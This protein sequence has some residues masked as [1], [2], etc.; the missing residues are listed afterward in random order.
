MRYLAI[1]SLE[2]LKLSMLFSM[3]FISLNIFV[4]LLFSPGYRFCR[5]F[6]A[7]C[8]Y[9]VVYLVPLC[10]LYMSEMLFGTFLV[11]A[12]DYE[13]YMM[14]QPVPVE[15]GSAF[16][17]SSA[18]SI[19]AAHMVERAVGK[20]MGEYLYE[21]VFQ[22]LDMG[23]PLWEHDPQGHPNGGGGMYLTCTEMMKLGQLYLAEG[24]WKGEQIV[25]RD[26]VQEVSTPKFTF[27]PSADLWHVGYGYQF[28]ISP[29][30]GSYRADGAFGQIT[31][32]LP[33][34]GLVVSIQCPERGN[35]DQ[36]KRALHEH[37][38]MEL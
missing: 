22:P 38:L 20:R 37:F 29:Y 28:W 15:P 14:A 17:Y 16:C 10:R 32:I 34:K 5:F 8:R 9:L 2:R 18:D 26:W 31:T 25:S 27:E 1:D 30:P 24:N 13:K 36:V 7:F 11:G 6:L 3:V 33:E 35:F 21:K 23:W 12:P 19:L 4:C